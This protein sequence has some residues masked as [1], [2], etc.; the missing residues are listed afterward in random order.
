VSSGHDVYELQANLVALGLAP[1]ALRVDDSYDWVTATAVRRWQASLGL[2]QTGIVRPGDAIYEPGP[3]R[4]TTVEPSTGMF[5]QPGQPVLEASSTQHT[6]I[7][8]L[9]VALEGLVKVG[10]AVTVGLPDGKTTAAAT[11]TA[12]GSVAVA[13]S[14]G[15]QGL[16]QNATATVT[17]TITLTDP[18]AAGTLDQAPVTVGIVNDVHKG[19]LAVP[20]TALVAQANGTYAVQVVA[21]GT[22]RTVTV[23]TGLYDDRGLVEVASSDLQEGMQVEVPTT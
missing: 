12:I 15:G 20:V 4:V 18:A 9:N 2:P 23:T 8:E 14:G 5:A 6:V 21:G 13:P 17:M 11:V 22:R 10:D 16:P 1:S 3:I 19:V 7:V